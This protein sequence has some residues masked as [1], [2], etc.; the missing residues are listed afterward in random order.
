MKAIN[1]FATV[2]TAYLP[3]QSTNQ[4]IETY[5]ISCTAMSKLY[6]VVVESAPSVMKTDGTL[7]SNNWLPTKNGGLLSEGMQNSSRS[8]SASFHSQRMNFLCE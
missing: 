5:C 3:H 2:F 8:H 1:L 7:N 4:Q 6:T